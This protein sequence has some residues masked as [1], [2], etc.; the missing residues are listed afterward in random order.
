MFAPSTTGRVVANA[1]PRTTD[2]R[3]LI[4]QIFFCSGGRV[5]CGCRS[6]LNSRRSTKNPQRCCAAF[7]LLELL[8]VVGIIGLLLV[9]IAPAFTY[10]KGGTDVT[11]AAYTIKGVLDTAHTYAKA[12]NTYTWVGFYE[13]NTANPASP[14][15]DTPAI[16]RLIMSIVASK[17]G[18][19]LY[20]APLNSVVTLAP[21]NLVQVGKLT[22]ID[23]AHLK[24]FPDPTSTPPP[25]DTFDTRPTPGTAPNDLT[26]RIG[27]DSTD[28]ATAVAPANPSLRFQYPLSGTASYTFGKVVQFT[29][30]GEGVIDNSNYTPKAVCEIGVEPTHGAAVPASVPANVIAIQFTGLGGSVKIYQR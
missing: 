24:T 4:A 5:G 22:K 11:S 14:N 9:L 30:R 15:L 27:N 20:T 2:Y 26:A 3:P 19:M 10:I 18:T 13:E 1:C 29:P 6:P 17:D 12:N 16:G 21:A 28:P 8:V 23:N 7:T 25:L